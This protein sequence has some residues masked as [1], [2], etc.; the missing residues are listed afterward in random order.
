[1]HVRALPAV[2]VSLVALASGA[3]AACSPSLG[4]GISIIGANGFVTPGGRGHGSPAPFWDI[5][6][7]IG[8]PASAYVFRDIDDTSVALTRNADNTV[9]MGA[10]ADTLIPLSQQFQIDCETCPA[11][12]STAAPGTVIATNCNIKPQ[13]DTSLCLQVD[14]AP[15]DNLFVGTCGVVPGA[16]RFTFST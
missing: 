11:E 14:R 15:S 4:A 3:H 7:L 10:T 8:L 5:I 16:Q 1:M 13:A 9:T 2:A 6:Q 12:A